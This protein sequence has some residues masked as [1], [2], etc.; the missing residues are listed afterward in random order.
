MRM[1]LEGE[2]RLWWCSYVQKDGGAY[3]VRCAAM[4]IDERQEQSRNK[5]PDLGSHSDPSQW[6][7]CV[8]FRT[9]QCVPV[10]PSRTNQ[11]LSGSKKK[12]K[13]QEGRFYTRPPD[14]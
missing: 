11:Q 7:M 2:V 4:R 8:Y 14:S 1:Q 10:R 6:F 12:R 9:Y 5:E 3:S 13:G